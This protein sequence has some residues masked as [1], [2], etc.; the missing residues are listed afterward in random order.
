[1]ILFIYEQFYFLP[2]TNGQSHKERSAALNYGALCGDFAAVICIHEAFCGDDTQEGRRPEMWR[3]RRQSRRL[4]SGNL[5][6]RHSVRHNVRSSVA[7][8]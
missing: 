8:S 6:A 5:T 3:P 2:V 4:R 7:G 1:M